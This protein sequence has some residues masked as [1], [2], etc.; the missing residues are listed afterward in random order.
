MPGHNIYVVTT[1]VYDALGSKTHALIQTL[2]EVY[3]GKKPVKIQI[4]LLKW[5]V[6]TSLRRV[7]VADLSE[8]G[9]K[10]GVLGFKKER[11]RL[12]KNFLT[13]TLISCYQFWANQSI[14]FSICFTNQNYWVLVRK[15][16]IM[17]SRK[18]SALE[19]IIEMRLCHWQDWWRDFKK[20]PNNILLLNYI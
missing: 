2:T 1:T 13:T 6:R 5:N 4:G 18:G 12:G 9:E 11:H 16:V 19:L 10:K 15:I 20:R 8:R 14:Q 3:F 7:K 17:I